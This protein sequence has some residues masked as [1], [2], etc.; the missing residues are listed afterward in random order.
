MTFGVRHAPK[1]MKKK[2]IFIAGTDTS[3]GKTHVAGGLA[4]ALRAQGKDV[5]VFK[6]F[7]SGVGSGHADYQ[8]LKEISGS[9][10]PDEWICPY[11]FEEAL[12]PMVAAERAGIA[13]DWCVVTDCFE[14]IAVKHD[15][16]IVEGAGGLLV[17]LAEGKT[18]LDLIR[19]CEFPVLLVARLGLGTINHTL[20]SLEAL[21][22]RKIE[23]IGIVLNQTTETAGVAEETNPSVLE[24]LAN[25]PVLGTVPFQKKPETGVFERILEKLK[26]PSLL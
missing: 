4:A 16:V 8:Y 24:K 6:P 19:E 12:A 5:G 20:L 11:R 17:P 9:R 14:S 7:E 22:T 1:T 13:I 18:N 21:A 3:V 15:F 23:C 25:V 26:R 2:G 10:D